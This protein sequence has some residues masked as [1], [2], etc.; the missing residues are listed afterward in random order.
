MEDRV[1]MALPDSIE[2]VAT[3]FAIAKTGAI[4]TMLNSIN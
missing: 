3:W 4:I 2:F 1:L